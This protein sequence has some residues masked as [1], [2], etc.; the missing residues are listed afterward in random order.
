M[1]AVTKAVIETIGDNGY[2]VEIGYADELPVVVAVNEETGESVCCS[3]AFFLGQDPVDLRV[4]K[5]IATLSASKVP[6]YT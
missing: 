3:F 2:R 4:R 5:R 6:T 1:D